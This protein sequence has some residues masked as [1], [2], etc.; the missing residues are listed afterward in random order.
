MKRSEEI[1]LLVAAAVLLA[2]GSLIVGL[3]TVWP[4]ARVIDAR[5]WLATPCRI[6]SCE[7]TSR[8]SRSSKGRTSTTWDVQAR[9]RY[10]VAGKEYISERFELGPRPGGGLDWRQAALARL[11]ASNPAQCW[12]DPRNPAAAVLERG[13]DPN[14]L[15]PLVGL[16][17][18]AFG[19]LL[20]AMSCTAVASA[21]AGN[22]RAAI[23]FG[24]TGQR[25]RWQR[26]R[27]RP[28]R[29]RCR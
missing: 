10:V 28:V 22:A 27:S 11:R 14:N 17:P 8:T 26:S 9:Y 2:V 29:T 21:G 23:A 1:G 24:S 4:L 25:P 15:V 3:C 13:F 12:V 20:A 19:G 7:L 6:E 16:A 18:M 5:D